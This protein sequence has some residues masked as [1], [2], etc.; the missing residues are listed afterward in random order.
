MSATTRNSK[1]KAQV[2]AAPSC[3]VVGLP[4]PFADFNSSS[5]RDWFPHTKLPVAWISWDEITGSSRNPNW[6]GFDTAAV[7]TLHEHNYNI[8]GIC[9]VA[10]GSYKVFARLYGNPGVSTGTGMHAACALLS[11]HYC[12][13]LLG[14][15]NKTSPDDVFEIVHS[16]D[17][18]LDFTDCPLDDDIETEG[19]YDLSE[20]KTK[21]ASS[22]SM[23]ALRELA[24][25]ERATSD[26][27]DEAEAPAAK[28][29][30]PFAHK[31]RA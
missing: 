9:G 26:E 15:G 14:R 16:E 12:P 22:L 1:A 27:A 5:V 30:C 28:A 11:Y 29:V 20:V 8:C 21:N 2:V 10:L 19:V 17:S 23:A 3:P 18:G 4:R 25:T 13:E 6:L 7:L 24:R 31:T